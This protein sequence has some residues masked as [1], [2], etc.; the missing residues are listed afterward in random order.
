MGGNPKVDWQMT[1][2]PTAY[3]L[4]NATHDDLRKA[5]DA[6]DL[7][8]YSILKLAEIAPGNPNEADLAF[9]TGIILAAWT[10]EKS[11]RP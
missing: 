5:A 8:A 11:R 9:I 10:G 3:R 2:E 7:M 4:I 6:G 1:E